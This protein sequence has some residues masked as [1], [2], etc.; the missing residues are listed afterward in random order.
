MRKLFNKRGI[1]RAGLAFLA[2]IM[3][4]SGCSKSKDSAS[5][6]QGPNEVWIEGMAFTPSTLSVTQG[7]T[8]TWTNKDGVTHNVTSSTA[9]FSSGSMSSGATFSYTFSAVGSYA[10]S[11]TIHPGMTGKVVVSASSP[12]Y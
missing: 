12:G 8:V 6:G 4:F 5:T 11:C 1:L 7:T 2:I 9:L 3:M 10:Y